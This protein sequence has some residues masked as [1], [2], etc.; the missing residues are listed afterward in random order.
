MEKR[1]VSFLILIIHFG[2]LSCMT[3][4]IS[5]STI[6]VLKTIAVKFNPN[7]EV[8]FLK[9]FILV[10]GSF[11]LNVKNL[12]KVAKKLTKVCKHIKFLCLVSLSLIF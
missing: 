10:F 3:L 1:I 12:T 2:F 4:N 7:L 6:E 11:I 5:K 9:L 8:L